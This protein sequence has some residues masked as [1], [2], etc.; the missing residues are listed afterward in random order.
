KLVEVITTGSKFEFLYDNN[1]LT[2]V[3]KLTPFSLYTN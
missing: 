3:N 1:Q 2:E